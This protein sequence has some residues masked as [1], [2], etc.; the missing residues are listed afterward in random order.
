MKKFLLKLLI[1]LLLLSLLPFSFVF[2]CDAY[3]YFGQN[4]STMPSDEPLPKMIAYAR[5][6]AP[7]I[8]IG[9]SRMNAIRIEEIDKLS[10]ES[11]R[12][13]SCGGMSVQEVTELF[14]YCESFGKLEKVYI[15]ASFYNIQTNYKFNR[16]KKLIPTLK[17]PVAYVYAF[18]T[19]VES[20]RYL[21]RKKDPDSDSTIKEAEYVK[22]DYNV[23]AKNIYDACAQKEGYSVYQ[24]SL[25]RL[26]EIAEYCKDNN[27][28]LVF[29]LPPYHHTI[30]DK[31]IKELDL[32]EEILRYQK[33]LAACAE[34]R[35]MEYFDEFSKRDENFGD[36]FHL[37]NE[38]LTRFTKAIVED[39]CD[40]MMKEKE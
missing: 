23:Y 20:F 31:V 15:G 30:Y 26:V 33:A 40:A 13:M 36:G 7:N 1:F 4:N 28:E 25:D 9:D 35:N 27:I 10:G 22:K 3:N 17:N 14:W 24:D 19:L 21:G 39:D 34:V 18:N 5:D 37:S 12:Q 32:E 8:I 6:P 38:A 29:V 11:Y 2:V 16:I